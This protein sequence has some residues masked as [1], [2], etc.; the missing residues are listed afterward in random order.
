MI[1]NIA[2]VRKKFEEFN[3]Q[4]FEGSLPQIP[5]RMSNARNYLGA[6]QYKVKRNLVGSLEYSN[7]VLRISMRFD[8]PKKEV[9]DT[10]L[11]EMIHLYIYVNG[12]KDSSAHGEV[13]RLMMNEINTKFGRNISIRHHRT[14]KVSNTDRKEKPHVVCVTRLNDGKR[15]VTVCARTRVID[16]YNVFNRSPQVSEMQWFYTTDPFFNRY[17]NSLTPKVYKIA[18]KDLDKHIKSAIPLECDGRRML[19]KK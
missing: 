16:I 7:L 15:F 13:F 4:C 1:P 19:R 12:I 5:I 10:I 6:V 14:D 11:H 2:Y 9:E 17:P 8:L 3:H 18:D